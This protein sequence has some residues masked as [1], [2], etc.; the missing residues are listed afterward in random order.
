MVVKYRRG[1]WPDMNYRI[2]LVLYNVGYVVARKTTNSML[3]DDP[4][5]FVIVLVIVVYW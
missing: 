3:V 5:A 1:I 4:S 2:G